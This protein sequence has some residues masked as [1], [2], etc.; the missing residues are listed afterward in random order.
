M[1]KI[2]LAVLAIVGVCNTT[3]AQYTPQKNDISA[4]ILFNPFK[5]GNSPIFS[6]NDDYA[7]KVR[8]MFT[9]K[10]ALRFKLGLGIDNNKSTLEETNGAKYADDNTSNYFESKSTETKNKTTSFSINVGYER[11]FPVSQRID[12]YAGGE[13][14]FKFRSCSGEATENVYR[15]DY[16][17]NATGDGVQTRYSA[18]SKSINF[19]KQHYYDINAPYSYLG[20]DEYSS[21]MFTVAALGGF[22]FYVYKGLYVGAELGIR[23]ANGKT[24]KK[25]YYTL[26]SVETQTV[27][28]DIATRITDYSS[29]TGIQTVTEIGGNET[30][31]T[32]TY[33]GTKLNEGST[34]TLKF[35]VEPNVRLGIK[36]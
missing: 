1:K 33:G 22:D 24:P 32:T 18:V 10:D 3:S 12:L 19:E 17:A 23:F 7:F 5:S 2:F 16:N 26:N 13:F 30:K 21:H 9:D 11:H 15:E 27:G 14:G 34:T 29:E 20:D 35:Y 4:E 36:F 25:A 6:L 31:T 28:N 8:W